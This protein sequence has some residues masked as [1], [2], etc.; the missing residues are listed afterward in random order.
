MHGTRNSMDDELPDVYIHGEPMQ[1][2]TA[3]A[4]FVAKNR[5]ACGGEVKLHAWDTWDNLADRLET[6]LG[7]HIWHPWHWQEVAR[8]PNGGVLLRAHE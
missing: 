5:A 4:Y 3:Q 8:K 7:Y 2:L 6:R 1:L